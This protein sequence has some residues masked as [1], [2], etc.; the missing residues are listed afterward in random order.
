MTRAAIVCAADPLLT[1]Y[2]DRSRAYAPVTYRYDDQYDGG[3]PDRP[4]PF[5][6]V[7]MPADDQAT[8]SMVDAWLPCS[9]SR[10]GA[11]MFTIVYAP[12]S[13]AWLI[14][15]GADSTPIQDRTVIAIFDKRPDAEASLARWRA[16]LA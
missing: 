15:F 6:T 10:L 8:A 9:D 5:L 7:D 4:T 11:D 13:C 3:G 14:L 16:A 12:V 2:I 1:V